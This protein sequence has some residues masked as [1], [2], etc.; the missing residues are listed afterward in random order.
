MNIEFSTEQE[1]CRRSLGVQVLACN[2]PTWIRFWLCSNKFPYVSHRLPPSFL[3]ETFPKHSRYKSSSMLLRLIALGMRILDFIPFPLCLAHSSKSD[4][5][6]LA[7]IKLNKIS[8]IELLYPCWLY[9]G[10][11]IQKLF[12]E[13]TTNNKAN[14]MPIN[15][16]FDLSLHKILV[17]FPELRKEKAKSVE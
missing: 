7:F 2:R 16:Q 14:K 8:W 11:I 15:K 17:P 12:T 3:T 6:K 5:L 4:L 13:T 10:L 1:F 9:A